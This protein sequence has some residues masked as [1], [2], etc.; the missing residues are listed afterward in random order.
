MTITKRMF[1]VVLA[2]LISI[3]LLGVPTVALAAT[4]SDTTTHVSPQQ[5]QEIKKEVKFIFEEASSY[6][7]GKVSVDM[8]K[9]QAAY[10]KKKAAYVAE[11]IRQLY[12]NDHLAQDLLAVS[13]DRSFWPCMKGELI[14]L[15]PGV[16]IYQL[17]VSGDLRAY[18]E[19][20]AWGKVAEILAEKLV[21]YGVRTN[22][23]GIVASIAIGA[24]KCLIWG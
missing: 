2:T 21:K 12:T 9:L 15:I 3:G 19:G 1:S 16:D 7:D 11:G 10:G 18:I 13:Q 17:I 20:K 23:A 5:L 24:G 6:K 22:V 4:P 14:G 8:A